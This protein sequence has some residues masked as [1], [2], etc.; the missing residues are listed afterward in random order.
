MICIHV[1]YSVHMK[2]IIIRIILNIAGTAMLMYVLIYNFYM[3]PKWK[4]SVKVT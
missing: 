1:V 2:L 4:N 3:K